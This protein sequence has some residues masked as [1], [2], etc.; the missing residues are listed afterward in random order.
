MIKI[1][2]VKLF[3]F[4]FILS[5][6]L[7]FPNVVMAQEALITVET[8]DQSYE[9]GETIVISGKV[10]TVIGETPILIQIFHQGNATE[11]LIEVRQIDVAQD[12]TFSQSIIAERPQWRTDG[13]Y[14]VRASYGT[15]NIAE[16]SFTFSTI[17][18]EPE[19]T[20][21]FEVDAG[22]AGTFDVEYTI[23][24]GTVKNMLVDPDIFALIVI[25]ENSDEGSITLSLPREYIDAKKQDGTDDTFIV[26]I[27]GLEV[28]YQEVKTEDDSRII[29]IQFEEGDSD[30][31]IIG[32][33]VIPEFGAIALLILGI[34][35][36]TIIIL[37][38]KSQ[39]LKV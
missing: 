37:S 15:A 31:E 13:E 33:F 7:I 39:F 2:Y 5:L 21:S 20:D 10:S 12:G 16:T 19:T 23:K 8:P 26:L 35:I 22:S 27:D 11:N 9:E 24:G 18:D 4:L 14:V 3:V 29:K 34:T 28:P 17:K 38:K 32:T 30:I 36:S 6:T 1:Q 25:V